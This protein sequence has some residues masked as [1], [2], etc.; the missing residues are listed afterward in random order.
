MKYR[1]IFQ[2]ETKK[3]CLWEGTKEFCEICINLLR[4][5]IIL[6]TKLQVKFF[7]NNLCQNVN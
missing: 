5:T 4:K 6:T 3:I 7:K 1:L 2:R